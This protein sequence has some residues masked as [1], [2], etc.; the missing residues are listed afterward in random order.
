[1][2]SLVAERSSIIGRFSFKGDCLHIFIRRWKII[3]FL[4]SPD[5]QQ[6]DKGKKDDRN[7]PQP[8]HFHITRINRYINYCRNSLCFSGMLPAN[9]KV[10]PN[11]LNAR[12][13]LNILPEISAFEARGIE[14]NKKILHSFAPSI[15]A[16]S[17][18][19][20]FTPLKS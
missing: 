5:S 17:S 10:A 2:G 4:F 6:H 12:A 9:I 3:S 7:H 13:R 16:A 19:S 1:M 8:C 15:L 20:R 14:I 11:S 18:M